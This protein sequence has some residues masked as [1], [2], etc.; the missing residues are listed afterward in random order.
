MIEVDATEW[1]VGPRQHRFRWSRV[2]F[3]WGWWMQESSSLTR[4]WVWESDG[5]KYPS[6]ARPSRS[7]TMT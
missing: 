1:T 5:N 7:F 4:T 2:R 3:E 6:I